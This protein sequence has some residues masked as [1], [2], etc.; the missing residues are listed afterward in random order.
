VIHSD[1]AAVREV[2]S[3][4]GVTVAREPRDSYPERLAQAVY[5][6]VNDPLLAGQLA[7][8]GPDR[9]RMFDWT[10]SANETW[11]LHADL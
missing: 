6:V 11:Q 7:V 9:A 1:D 5:Q 8:A 4:A 2:A 10:D 3:D